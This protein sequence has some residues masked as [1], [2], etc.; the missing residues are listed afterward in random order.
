MVEDQDC[1]LVWS[2]IDKKIGPNDISARIIGFVL[3]KEFID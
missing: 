2:P 1:A 3:E